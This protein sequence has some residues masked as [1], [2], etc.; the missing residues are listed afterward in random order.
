MFI[1]A[2]LF[3]DES[4]ATC[5]NERKHHEFSDITKSLVW[6]CLSQ[7]AYA[8]EVKKSKLNDEAL[9]SIRDENAR[10]EEEKDKQLI[11]ELN[12]QHHSHQEDG[13]QSK[14]KMH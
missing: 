3:G 14:K 5:P 4:M 1:S 11:Q 7:E 10:K 6:T 13:Q 9:N 8:E 2:D 12:Q